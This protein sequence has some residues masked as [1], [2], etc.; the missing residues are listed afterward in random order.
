MIL[1]FGM[2]QAQCNAVYRQT[3]EVG[4]CN[5]WEDCIVSH[6]CRSGVVKCELNTWEWQNSKVPITTLSI[7]YENTLF[8]QDPQYATSNLV[9]PHLHQMISVLEMPKFTYVHTVQRETIS[10]HEAFEK[11]VMS[12]DETHSEG[13]DTD[14]GDHL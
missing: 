7:P 4:I 1:Q 10:I 6:I 13:Q 3:R 9:M 5:R 12:E 11:I 2:K 14:G 8:M